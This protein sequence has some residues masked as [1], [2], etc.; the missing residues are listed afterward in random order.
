MYIYWFYIIQVACVEDNPPR[1]VELTYHLL[2]TAPCPAEGTEVEIGE[3]NSVKTFL[4]AVRL[5]PLDTFAF[6]NGPYTSIYSKF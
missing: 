4:K 5:V 2:E 1:S 6:T 3:D